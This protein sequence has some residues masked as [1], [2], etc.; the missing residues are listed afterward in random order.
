MRRI[1]VEPLN[2]KEMQSLSDFLKSSGIRSITEE[3]YQFEKQME[4]RKKLVELS[5]T[6]PKIDI[7]DEEIDEMVNEVRAK[8]YMDENKNNH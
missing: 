4:A 3:E 1:I 2:E 6:I 5:K 8:R 7:T